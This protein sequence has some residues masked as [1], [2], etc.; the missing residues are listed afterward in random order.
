MKPGES[1]SYYTDEEENLSSQTDNSKL[2]EYEKPKNN[3]NTDKKNVDDI[4]INPSSDS[5]ID[6]SDNTTL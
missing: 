3:E 2:H 1:H 4:L 5:T 6:K